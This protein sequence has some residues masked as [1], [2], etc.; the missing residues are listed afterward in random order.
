MDGALFHRC[1]FLL[2]HAPVDGAGKKLRRPLF[3]QF[4]LSGQ[5]FAGQDQ[6]HRVVSVA[7]SL[8]AEAR[9]ILG[10]PDTGGLQL[11]EPDLFFRLPG[12]RIKPMGGSSSA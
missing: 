6:W 9:Q 2:E 5:L 7:T 8:V 4:R 11:Q 3:G 1:P 10:D 12:Q